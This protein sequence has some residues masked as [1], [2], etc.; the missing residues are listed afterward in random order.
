MLLWSRPRQPSRSPGHRAAEGRHQLARAVFHGK[1]G[2][3]RQRYPFGA[4]PRDAPPWPACATATVAI[5]DAGLKIGTRTLLALFGGRGAAKG[6]GRLALDPE[7]VLALLSIAACH[8]VAARALVGIEAAAGHWARGDRAL[9][10]IR[11]AFA[12]LPQLAEPVDVARLQAA[13]WLLDQGMTPR[14]LMKELGLDT[15]PLDEAGDWL[16]KYNPD[17]PRVPAGHGVESGRWGSSDGA[18]AFDL[19]RGPLRVSQLR[20][21]P[22]RVAANGPFTPGGFGTTFTTPTSNPLDPKGLNKPPTPEEQQA[23]IDALNTFIAGRGPRLRKLSEE[24]YKNYPH[25]KTGAVL[26]D[27]PGNYKEYTVRTPG[28]FDRGERRLII[29]WSSGNMYYTNKHYRSFYRL[30]IVPSLTSP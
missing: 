15:A 5:D 30:H 16:D 28:I 18:A 9:A 6:A 3:L 19:P 1:R 27:S 21:D 23:I 22:V 7:R 12:G 10:T 24:P 8:P 29:D 2:E 25:P 11:L 17:Q 26:P 4:G 14:R 13:A 20:F